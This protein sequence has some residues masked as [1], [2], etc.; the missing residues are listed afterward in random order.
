MISYYL[1]S[2][3]SIRWYKKLLDISL[4]NA[5]YIKR[6]LHTQLS[7]LQFCQ[8]IVKEYLGIDKNEQDGRNLVKTGSL[9]SGKKPR[10]D[11]QI[12]NRNTDSG[13]HFLDKIPNPKDPNKSYHLRCKHCTSKSIRKK[14]KYL[15]LWVEPCLEDNH[16]Q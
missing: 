16:R 1:S 10:L 6:T 8:E 12:A 14:T 9:H 15:S 3:K 4:W 2:R 5:F 11:Q 13:M 7:F